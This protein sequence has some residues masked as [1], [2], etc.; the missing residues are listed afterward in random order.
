MKIPFTTEP[1]EIL[2]ISSNEFNVHQINSI[3]SD[4]PKLR[5]LSKSPTFALTYQGTYHTLMKNC[6]FTE[7]Q[8][9]AIEASYHQLYQQSSNWIQS[10]L[11]LAAKEGYITAAFGLR[12]RTP[13]LAQV[14]RG[15]RRT[16]YE[17]QA[18]SRTAG[19]ALGQSWGLLNSRA[20]I[21]CM[22]RVRNSQYRLAI[23]PC[24]HIHDA[25]YFIIKDSAETLIYLNTILV[26]AAEWQNHPEI[27]HPSIKLGGKLSVFFPT[28]ANN[29]TIPNSI[30]EPELLSL[31]QNYLGKLYD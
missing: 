2:P 30:T 29:L 20:S 4:Y 18:E 16:P 21:E 25:Q 1:K 19:N 22:Q 28:W 3:A 9:K 11:D 26:K 14:I 17:A 23:K 27:Y 12:V 8:A 7:E 6:G 15:I 24:A 10:K 13:I 5:Q 31:V